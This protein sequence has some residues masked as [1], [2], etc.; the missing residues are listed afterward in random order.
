MRTT[1]ATF[2]ALTLCSASAFA[3]QA[4]LVVSGPTLVTFDTASPTVFSGAQPITGLGAGEVLVGADFRP[5]TGQLFALTRDAGGAGRLYTI[6]TNTAAATL[7]A[8]LAADPTDS[9]APYT[10]LAGTQPHVDFN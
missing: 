10:S 4:Y 2:L 8:P 7:V 1:V 6:D 5:A 9:T 3:T